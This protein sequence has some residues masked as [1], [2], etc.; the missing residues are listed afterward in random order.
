[1]GV[2]KAGVQ[3]VIPVQAKLGRDRHSIVQ[4]KQDFHCCEIR[5]PELVCR[6]VS[7]Q[8]LDEGAIAMFELTVVETGEV[9]IVQE[10]HY[11]LAPI[12]GISENDLRTYRRLS[13]N[14]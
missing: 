3:Y 9:K 4:T 11:L 13:G 2:D 7:A 12:E 10:R 5:F 14:L 1:M 6:A 8:F